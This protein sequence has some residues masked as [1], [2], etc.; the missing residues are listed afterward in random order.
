M[1]S[2]QSQPQKYQ[3]PQ[4]ESRIIGVTN[5]EIGRQMRTFLNQSGKMNCKMHYVIHFKNI[6]R[7]QLKNVCIFTELINYDE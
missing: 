6:Q 5:D 7:G 2:F 4:P 1:I 3:L